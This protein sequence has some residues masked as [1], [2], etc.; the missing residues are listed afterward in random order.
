VLQKISTNEE[1]LSSFMT[2][3]T[4]GPNDNPGNKVTVEPG[5]EEIIQDSWR[6]GRVL[7]LKILALN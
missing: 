7:N 3:E 2:Q 6:F 1:E 5:E 4:S